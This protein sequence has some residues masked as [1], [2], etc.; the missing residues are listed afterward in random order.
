MGIQR[1]PTPGISGA[2]ELVGA[3]PAGPS[4]LP[5]SLRTLEFDS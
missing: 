5:A 2:G 4:E 1:R 3:V